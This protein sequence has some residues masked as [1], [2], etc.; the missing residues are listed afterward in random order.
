MLRKGF[1][2]TFARFDRTVTL[3]FPFFFLHMARLPHRPPTMSFAE[4]SQSSI[5]AK[6]VTED[7]ISPAMDDFASEADYR[8]NRKIF[9][10]LSRYQFPHL[11][12]LSCFLPSGR[13]TG[14]PQ[15]GDHHFFGMTDDSKPPERPRNWS[16][17]LSTFLDSLRRQKD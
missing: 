13:R 9:F 12:P 8:R 2:L 3:I 4:S 1:S 5:R 16:T 7:K 17:R 14:A 11:I 10:H 15:F 6:N